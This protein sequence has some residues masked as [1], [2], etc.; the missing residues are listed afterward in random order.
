M[1]T[2][3]ETWSVRV[4]GW[5]AATVDAIAALADAIAV[6]DAAFDGAALLVSI[7]RGGIEAVSKALID[8]GAS[9]RA[10][11]LVGSHARRYTVATKVLAWMVTSHGPLVPAQ[12]GTQRGNA[13]YSASGFPLSRD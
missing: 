7:P 13:K 12:A 9:I 3:V 1:A 4:A 11:A 2:E 8:A 6:P 10:S 5:S